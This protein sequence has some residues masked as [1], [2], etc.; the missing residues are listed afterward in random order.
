MSSFIAGAA[1]ENTLQDSANAAPTTVAEPARRLEPT[2]SPDQGLGAPCGA[3]PPSSLATLPFHLPLTPVMFHGRTCSRAL[4]SHMDARLK[5]C[6]CSYQW[7]PRLGINCCGMHYKRT[8][9]GMTSVC[10]SQQLGAMRRRDGYWGGHA[11]MLCDGSDEHPLHSPACTQTKHYVSIIWH[12][13]S[14]PLVSCRDLCRVRRAL[15]FPLETCTC[16]DKPATPRILSAS[17]E[18]ISSG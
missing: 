4:Q 16:A 9:Q 7:P 6:M 14:V 18:T 13:A 1:L 10:V 15:P 8:F 5:A 17:L 12:S 2:G 3:R 11:L